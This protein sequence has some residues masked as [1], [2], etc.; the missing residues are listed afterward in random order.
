MPAAAVTLRPA[1]PPPLPQLGAQ[2]TFKGD[3]PIGSIMAMSDTRGQ[4]KGKV[5]NAEAD[6]PLRPDGKLNVGAAVGQGAWVAR[7]NRPD[8]S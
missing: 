3:G 2:V 8:G 7:D 5:G 6:P 4:V 1:A